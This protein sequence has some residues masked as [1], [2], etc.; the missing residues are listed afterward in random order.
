MLI[1]TPSRLHPNDLYET[2]A[3]AVHALLCAEKLPRRVWECACGRGA[4]V[5]VLRAAGHEVLAT[6]LVDYQSPDQDEAGRD[7]LLEQE[8]PDGVEAILTNP[9][10]ALAARFVTRGLSLCP[11]VI[12]LLRLTF[13]E[14][15][16]GANRSTA[17]RARALALD[18]GHLARVHVFRN[19]LPALH[20]D[21]WTGPRVSNPTAYAWFVWDRTHRGP[22]E[23]RR[24]SWTPIAALPATEKST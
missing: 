21:G 15:G 12:M 5:R 22:A 10:G 16:N 11:R 23:V 2:P 18:G 19:R 24:I 20:R 14:G 9:P 3:E 17:S 1:R 8:L 6:D 7:F 13:L 4:I